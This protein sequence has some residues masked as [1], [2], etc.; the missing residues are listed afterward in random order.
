MNKK[1]ENWKIRHSKNRKLR[2]IWKIQNSKKFKIQK[3]WKIEKNSKNWKFR[4][5]KNRKLRK[6]ENSGILKIKNWEKFE[7]LKIWKKL[8]LQNWKIFKIINQI[9]K[10]IFL[11]PFI[12][13]KS[14]KILDVY[15][16]SFESENESQNKND[17]KQFYLEKCFPFSRPTS[18]FFPPKSRFGF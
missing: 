17:A 15:G 18:Q 6:I 13:N 8:G 4:H 5:S 11:K 7:K 16:T 2:K 9:F 14:W 12:I 1:S 10:V 3:N